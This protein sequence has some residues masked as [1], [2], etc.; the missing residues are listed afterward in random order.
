MS[1]LLQNLKI[2]LQN[3]KGFIGFLFSICISGDSASY[4]I[5]MIMLITLEYTLAQTRMMFGRVTLPRKGASEGQI[6]R[7]YSKIQKFIS[8]IFCFQL[9]FL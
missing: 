4:F 6:C 5:Q 1:S 9:Q 8:Y 7:P 2:F 3:L